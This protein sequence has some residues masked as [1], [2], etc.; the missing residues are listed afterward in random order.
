MIADTVVLDIIL[1]KCYSIIT[2]LIKRGGLAMEN[3]VVK[4]ATDVLKKLTPSNQAY[5]MSLVRLAEAAENSVKDRK[6]IRQSCSLSKRK[7]LSQAR[8]YIEAVRR[9]AVKHTNN[10]KN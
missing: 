7:S 1:I 4:E 5:F 6:I 8:D 10:S 9:F 3:G 2:K